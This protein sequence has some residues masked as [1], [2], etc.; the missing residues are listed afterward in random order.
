MPWMLKSSHPPTHHTLPE[1]PKREGQKLDRPHSRQRLS[2]LNQLLQVPDLEA[3]NLVPPGNAQIRAWSV[4]A[5][6]VQQNGDKGLHALCLQRL[7]DAYHCFSRQIPDQIITVT[8]QIN[9]G[10][11]QPRDDVKQRRPE[12]ALGRNPGHGL[13]DP[14]LIR[15]HAA[16]DDSGK[17]AGD[18]PGVGQLDNQLNGRDPGVVLL[19]R[20]GLDARLLLREDRVHQPIY[21][22]KERLR[23]LRRKYVQ[24]LHRVGPDLQ[25]LV[26]QPHLDHRQEG[27]NQTLQVGPPHGP[28]DLQDAN[29]RPD[30]HRPVGR[31]A[32]PAPVHGP[33]VTQRPPQVLVEYR[34]ELVVKGA[35]EL[36]EQVLQALDRDIVGVPGAGRGQCIDDPPDQD[37]Q[38]IL[39]RLGGVLHQRL[40]Q[41]CCT[42]LD[43]HVLVAPSHVDR[44]QDVGSPV[45]REACLAQG[46]GVHAEG[47]ASGVQLTL[48]ESVE[49]SPQQR[50][51]AEP[52]SPV[53]TAQPLLQRLQDVGGVSPPRPP[54]STTGPAVSP[55][56]KD[57]NPP[58]RTAGGTR[59]GQCSPPSRWPPRPGRKTRP[60]Q[61]RPQDE[62][63]TRRRRCRRHPSFGSERL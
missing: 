5:D 22:R 1:A 61:R 45:H 21:R 6:D 59:T 54:V 10:L 26:T 48:D 3:L 34:E 56:S 38:N 44:G 33:V 28:Q 53:V 7:D 18:D 29:A 36:V 35:P 60:G 52:N 17:D 47:A 42:V 25:V 4:L 46:R 43:G 8:V 50:A 51:A 23:V 24:T 20:T 9:T 15:S 49:E 27:R 63:E 41:G 32:S 30:S 58:Q 57:P 55:A 16:G 2:P 37:G 40:P 11:D 31:D 62:E 12:S 13:N 14:D 39:E 19:R